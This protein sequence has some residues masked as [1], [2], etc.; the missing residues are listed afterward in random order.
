M[1]TFV[2]L[3][4]F[5]THMLTAVVA[6]KHAEHKALKK[7]ALLIEREAKSEIGA[8]QPQVGPFPEWAPLADSTEAQKAAKGYPSGAPL[9]ATGKMRDNITHEIDGLDAVIGSPDDIAV[10][11]EFG[12]SKMPPRPIFGPAAYKN[13]EKLHLIIGT[14][15]VAGIIEGKVASGGA[16]YFIGGD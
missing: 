1:K 8:Y 2:S 3:A 11:H 6:M 15:V 12:T 10:F 4:D 13:L 5:A 16:D 7:A 9:L 14:E